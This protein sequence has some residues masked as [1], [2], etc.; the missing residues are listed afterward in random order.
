M[1]YTGE[2][3]YRLTGPREECSRYIPQARTFLGE[4][5]NQQ[6][7]LGGVGVFL[8]RR[9]L[10]NGVRIDV[11]VFE[12]APPIIEIE[13]IVGEDSFDK[14]AVQL[15]LAWKPEGIILTPKAPIGEEGEEGW[16]LPSRLAGE[17]GEKLSIPVDDEGMVENE[18]GLTEGGPLAQCILNRYENNKYMDK[19]E[20]VDG[21]PEYLEALRGEPGTFPN[22]V[23]ADDIESAVGNPEV[24]YRVNHI[25]SRPWSF[26]SP[27]DEGNYEDGYYDGIDQEE[28]ESL[29]AGVYKIQY[30]TGGG[31]VSTQLAVQFDENFGELMTEGKTP[32][33]YNPDTDEFDEQWY[34]HRPEEVLYPDP[35]SET[36]FQYT[37]GLRE[38]VGEPV[39]WRMLR[40]DANSAFLAGYTLTASEGLFYHSHPDFLPGYRSTGGRVMNAIGVEHYQAYGDNVRE[41][42]AAVTGYPDDVVTGEERGTY[43]AQLWENS[44]LHYAN[45]ISDQWS[46]ISLPITTFGTNGTIGASHQIGAYGTNDY[47]ERGAPFDS[48]VSTPITPPATGATLWAQIFCNR[49]TWLP[50]YDLIHEGEYGATGIM[51][52]WN[53]YA[54]SN[55]V[56]AS[57]QVGW[58]K[59]VYQLPLGLVDPL[60]V[61]ADDE[62]SDFL[63]LVGSAMIEI[64]GEKWI[65]AVYYTSPMIEESIEAED[66]FYPQDGDSVKMKVVRWPIRLTEASK[67][68]WR[69]DDPGVV[70]ETEYE[71]EW[72]LEDGWQANPPGKV[73]FNSTGDKFTFTMHKMGSDI[74][75]DSLDFRGKDWTEDRSTLPTARRDLQCAHHEWSVEMLETMAEMEVYEPTPL[76]ATIVAWTD[77]DNAPIPE[78]YTDSEYT[79]FYSRDLVGTYDMFPH[80][81]IT[82]ENEITSEDL[83]YV[84]LDVK[85]HSIQWGNRAKG[86]EYVDKICECYRFRK[87]VFPSGKEVTYMQQYME[88]RWTNHPNVEEKEWPGTGTENFYCVIHYMDEVNE[89]LIYS[90]IITEKIIVNYPGFPNELYRTDGD[91]IYMLD[92]NP[93]ADELDLEAEGRIEEEMG[94]ILYDINSSALHVYDSD[95]DSFATDWRFPETG[96][97]YNME[98]SSCTWMVIQDDSYSNVPSGMVG[99]NTT[100]FTVPEIDAYTTHTPS[101]LS[102]NPDPEDGLYTRP[103]FRGFPDKDLDYPAARPPFA[104]YTVSAHTG[105]TY[106]GDS[107]L[108]YYGSGKINYSFFRCN[109]APMF[110]KSNETEA[111]V[112]RY[113]G[114]YVARVGIKHVHKYGLSSPTYFKPAGSGFQWFEWTAIPPPEGQ[115]Q[116]L[117]ANFDL[118]EA[119]GIEDLRDIWPMGKIV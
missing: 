115:E 13:V 75:T 104:D 16:G 45:M 85:E 5:W 55:F 64:E 92:M 117:W 47:V 44:P 77:H 108:W 21:L 100:G 96:W 106:Y 110:G 91:I 81:L 11:Y 95:G 61:N 116:F 1:R 74:Y 62:V 26:K 29:E 94:R 79:T 111:K 103:A 71:F 78:S 33:V 113:D 40:G 7:T 35:V 67:L 25:I 97:I 101:P 49:V 68:P 2:V 51:N 39:V 32:D 6:R 3:R 65:R 15:R 70:Y 73:V 38:A 80:Y 22:P 58:N 30:L 10:P 4:V 59:H 114:R 48:S 18:L 19:I 66:G 84:Q 27:D 12:D 50:I 119:T 112:L 89:D 57:R 23:L 24:L 8:R 14:E 102:L 41:N 52:G 36:I 90:K 54:H 34:C 86:D 28:N 37:N 76:V 69:D 109:I 20:F 87:L 31:Y 99:A 42:I 9:T 46:D 118:D 43:I 17:T 83:A 53:P 105:Y 107:N 88:E 56:S 82:T 60:V 93:V 63:A 98:T 72:L